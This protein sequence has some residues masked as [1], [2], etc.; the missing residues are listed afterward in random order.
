VRRREFIGL[1]GG[2]AAAWPLAARAQQPERMCRIGILSDFSDADQQPLISVFRERLQKL[3]WAN[4]NIRI[5]Y[6]LASGVAAQFQTAAAALIGLAPDVVVTQS[7]TAL[8]A[9]R[10]ETSTIPI[11]FTLVADPVAQGFIESLARPGGNV[12]GFTNF[13]FSFA[14]KWLEALKEIMPRIS[15]VIV[16]INPTNPSG[17]GLLRF[18][19]K[20]GPSY[21]VEVISMAVTTAAEIEG[22]FTKIGNAQDRGMIIL[23]DGLTIIHRDLTIELVKRAR[24]PAVFAFRIFPVN[25]GLLSWGMDFPEVYRQAASYVDRI[26]RGAK[27]SDLPVQAP[28]KF[29]LVIN[30]KT[31]RALGVEVPNSIQLLADEIIE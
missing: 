3:G 14:G 28:T 1:L 22:A 2:A 9:M 20:L 11:V 5:D 16:I 13:E 26:L 19:E 7:S 31:A 10:Q 30:L 24:I 17:A 8:R 25:G 27:P 29:E 12:T 21:G 15:G 4:A 6:R 18:I 23:P